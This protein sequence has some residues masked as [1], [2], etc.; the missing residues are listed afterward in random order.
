[1]VFLRSAF[2]YDDFLYVILGV[3]IP[4]CAWARQ[5]VRFAKNTCFVVLFRLN[6][7]ARLAIFPIEIQQKLS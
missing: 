4:T 3:S 5:N 7:C 2:L 1:M 6:V